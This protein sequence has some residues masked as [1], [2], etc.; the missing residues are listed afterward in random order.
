MRAALEYGVRLLSTPPSVVH[1]ESPRL[2]AEV[3]LRHA[4]G[5]ERAYLYAHLDDLLAAEHASAFAAALQRRASGEPVA[6]VTGER[7]VMGHRFHVDGRVL[8]PRPETEVLIELA[9]ERLAGIPGPVAADVGTGSGAIAVSLAAARSDL[10][11]YATDVSAEALAVAQANAAR[12][13]GPEQERVIF[14][15]CALLAGIDTPLH[16]IAA[17]LPYIPTG[18]LDL[19]SPSIRGFEPRAALDG[20]DDGLDVYRALLRLLP[21]PLV[22]GGVVLLECDPEQTGPLAALAAAALPGVHTS[23]HHDLARQPR[24]VELRLS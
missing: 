20:G 23:I 8:V 2:D 1:D 16:L 15:E 17:N 9:L 19:L 12:I 13:M 10:R 22:K 6:Y 21:G 7:E 18:R 4:L 3:L 11:V 5:V 14:R 24:I